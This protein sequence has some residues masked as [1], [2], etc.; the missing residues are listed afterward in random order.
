MLLRAAIYLPQAFSKKSRSETVAQLYVTGVKSM[1]V[2]TVVAFFTGMILALQAGLTL[3]DYG[4]ESSIST[5]VA[6]TIFREMGPF[7]T[8]LIIAASV[9]SAICAQLGTMT[10]S[11][12]VAALEV[13]SI[14]P[15]RFLVM[16]RLFALMIMTPLLTVYANA[17]GI[18]GG[19]LVGAFQ[20]NVSFQKYFD[21]AF[22]LTGYKDLLLGLL[23]AFFFGLIITTVS[24]HQGFS[25]RD[26][27]V[28]VGR[29]TRRTVVVS[30][31]LILVVGYFLTGLFY[32]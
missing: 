24:C 1:G 9:G 13:M 15:H 23:K 18:L 5:F 32:R 22:L 19:S 27:A 2:I 17:L 6:V 30:F 12:E 31:L 11:E 20:L 10:V 29:N 14:D 16:P 25:T 28:G 21:N 4:Q 26:G 7:M 3:R 8:G